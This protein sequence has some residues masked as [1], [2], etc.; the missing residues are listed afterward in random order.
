LWSWHRA[1]DTVSPRTERD[2]ASICS[3][4]LSITNRTLNRWF[5]SFTPSARNPVAVS[6]RFRSASSFAGRRSPAIC[7]RTKLIEGTSALTASMT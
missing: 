2:T 5:T 3:S 1:H 7:S 4:T 6:S